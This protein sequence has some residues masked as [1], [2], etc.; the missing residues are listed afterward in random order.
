MNPGQLQDQVQVPPR[1]G[2]PPLRQQRGPDDQP[3]ASSCSFPQPAE[4]FSEILV[5]QEVNHVDHRRQVDRVVGRGDR[6]SLALGNKTSVA[7]RHGGDPD[8]FRRRF[9]PVQA[10]PGEPLEKPAGGDTVT[11]ADVQNRLYVVGGSKHPLHF[12]EH[13]IQ[14][15]LEP[16]KEPW[17]GLHVSVAVQ[18]PLLKGAAVDDPF[19][20]V[21][22]NMAQHGGQNEERP[23][24]RVCDAQKRGDAGALEQ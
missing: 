3:P 4:S 13:R 24:H 23:D 22:F 20:P 16:C 2:Q 19:L 11:S 18:Y 21:L 10:R 7:Y 9:D 15:H 6:R 5:C 17:I 14:A 8:T 1:P 12:R